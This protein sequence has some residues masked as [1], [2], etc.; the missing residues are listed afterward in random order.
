MLG[1]SGSLGLTSHPINARKPIPQRP[2]LVE[3]SGTAGTL[4]I[5][6]YCAKVTVKQ[7][8]DLLPAEPDDDDLEVVVRLKIP[9]FEPEEFCTSIEGVRLEIDP[10]TSEPRLLLDCVE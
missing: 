5:R 9:V 7:L 4:Q 1:R 8:R 10:D 3:R 6:L 2:V